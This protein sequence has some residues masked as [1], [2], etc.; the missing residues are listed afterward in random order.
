VTSALVAIPSAAARNVSETVGQYG[1]VA[2][3]IGI[4]SAVIGILAS[5]STGPPAGPM[6]ILTSV[7]VFL[8][9]VP[10]A[11]FH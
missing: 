10:L 9:T 2:A 3:A 1:V 11:E 8:A 7:A 6:V 5:V 4:A